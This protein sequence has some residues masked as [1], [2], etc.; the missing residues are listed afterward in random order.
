MKRLFA[1][2]AALCCVALPAEA[3]TVAQFLAKAH[4]LQA[5]GVLAL[6]SP[7]LKLLQDEMHGIADAYRHDVDAAKAAHRSPSSCP[8]LKGQAKLTSTELIG[9]LER[10]PSAQRGMDLK[11]AF[12]AIMRRRYPC[13]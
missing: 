2:A 9:E 3:M 12:Y 6:T 13:R 8:P 1:V 5:Q 7:D 10:I 11:P 4:A